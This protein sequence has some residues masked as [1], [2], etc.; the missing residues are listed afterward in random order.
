[1]FVTLGPNNTRCNLNPIDLNNQSSNLS[2]STGLGVRIKMVGVK[3]TTTYSI[4]LRIPNGM[5][6]KPLHLSMAEGPETFT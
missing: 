6:N 1:M 3:F 4:R 5:I 2:N